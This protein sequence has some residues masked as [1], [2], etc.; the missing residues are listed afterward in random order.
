MK[1][2][3]YHLNDLPSINASIAPTDVLSSASYKSSIISPIADTI[4]PATIAFT[5]FAPSSQSYARPRATSVTLRDSL[6]PQETIGQ[7]PYTHWVGVGARSQ[8]LQGEQ[9]VADLPGEQRRR[10]QMCSSLVGVLTPRLLAPVTRRAVRASG[11]ASVGQGRALRWRG[12]A[13]ER[14]GEEGHRCTTSGGAQTIVEG[15]K[16]SEVV[17]MTR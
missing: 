2:C 8:V 6:P 11:S 13:C 7:V 1:G 9:G 3:K 17:E 10:R 4:I 14:E 5:V 15:G 12:L 16:G